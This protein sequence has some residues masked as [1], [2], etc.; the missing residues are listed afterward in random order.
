MGRRCG[1]TEPDPCSGLYDT[2]V[3]RAPQLQHSVQ[4]VGRD[5]HLARLTPV[6]LRTQPI[7]CT[8]RGFGTSDC[9][10][11]GDGSGLKLLLATLGWC[12]EAVRSI[13]QVVLPLPPEH[14]RRGRDRAQV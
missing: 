10:L 2:D 6:R 5:G 14:E 4:H 8:A 7:A 11:R 3:L 13:S 12:E 9:T 1:R